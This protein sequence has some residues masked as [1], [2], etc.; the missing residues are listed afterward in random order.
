MILKYGTYSHAS[1]EASI[2]VEKKVNESETGVKISFTETWTITGWLHADDTAGLTTAILAL[3]S[4]YGV[5]GYDLGLYLD[6]GATVTAHYMQ[7]ALARGGTRVK[8]LKYPKG[9]GAEYTTYRQYEIIVEAEF[10]MGNAGI[11]AYE[12]TVTLTGGGPLYV[13]LETLTGPPQKQLVKQQTTYKA[14][15]AGSAT[16][17]IAYPSIPAPL[18]PDAEHVTRRSIAKMHPRIARQTLT[19]YTVSWSYEFES[20]TPLIGSP[21]DTRSP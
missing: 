19:D 13:F 21:A 9:D 20:S 6:D 11:T 7:T 15:Q 18:W 5:N 8:S 17:D 1:G 14:T 4:A 3:E 2:V 16:G 10:P 12:E